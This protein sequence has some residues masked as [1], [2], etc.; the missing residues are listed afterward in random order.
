ML[1]NN[2]IIESE[3]RWSVTNFDVTQI[4]IIDIFAIEQTY[5]HSDVFGWIER[6]RERVNIFGKKKYFHTYKK[7]ISPGKN[8]ENEE[9]ISF[10]IHNQN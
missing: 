2:S 10:R 1:N 8:H 3:R 4:P 9:E 7:Y 5:L 6:V